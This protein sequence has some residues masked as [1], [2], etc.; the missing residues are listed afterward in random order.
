MALNDRAHSSHHSYNHR[1]AV[2]LAES[3]LPANSQAVEK[4][5]HYLLEQGRLN[6]WF[7][8]VIRKLSTIRIG[9][10]NS[11]FSFIIVFE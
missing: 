10:D 11:L 9:E 8:K 6:P 3:M 4:R 2:V 5:N 7:Y 1:T